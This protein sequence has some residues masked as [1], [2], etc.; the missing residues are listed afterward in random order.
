MIVTGRGIYEYCS[1]CG[2]LVQLNKWLTGDLHLC[3][4]DEE[5]STRDRLLEAKR[6]DNYE[7]P[8]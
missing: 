4:T 5:I 3:L 8:N 2:K 7:R 6:R 1:V